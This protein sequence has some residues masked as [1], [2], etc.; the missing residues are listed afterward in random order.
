MV[1]KEHQCWLSSQIPLLLAVDGACGET[2]GNLSYLLHSAPPGQVITGT[3]DL[4]ELSPHPLTFPSLPGIR[5]VSGLSFVDIL[6]VPFLYESAFDSQ[7][8]LLSK[9]PT[10]ADKSFGFLTQAPVASFGDQKLTTDC[11]SLSQKPKAAHR[12]ES[13]QPN[14]G[15][16]AY[17]NRTCG[18]PTHINQ[19]F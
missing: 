4:S 6:Y 2:L 7:N 16:I 13:F 5:L 8:F 1:L 10:P 14:R 18:K 3:E 17:Q 12:N 19:Y 9:S 11:S 15:R